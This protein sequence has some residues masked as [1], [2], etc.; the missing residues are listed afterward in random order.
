MQ[1]G[2]SNTDFLSSSSTANSA[3]GTDLSPLSTNDTSLLDAYSRAVTTAVEKVSP[4]V[5][6]VEVYQSA[7]RGRSGERR[8]G[9]SGF[10]F[11]PDGLILTNSHVV[12]DATRI[13]VTFADGTRASA[14]T[15]GDDPATDLAVIQVSAPGLTAVQ[16]GD[17]Q[18]LRPGQMAIAIGNPYGFQ[19][20]VTAGVISALG[21]SLRS[22]SGRLIEDV[23]QTDAALNPGNSGGPLVDSRGQVIGVNTATILPA[24]G[25]C[26]AIGINTAKFVAS[27]LL[28][29]GRIRRSYI[30]VSAQTVPIHRRVVRFYNLPQ[31]TGVVVLGVEERSPAQRAGL[32][33]GDV[34]VALND[35]QVAGVDDLHRLLTDAQ[36]GA[37]SMLTAIRHTERITLAISPEEAKD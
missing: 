14:R 29:D 9:G 27:R 20:T 21:R 16:F 28:R 6:N 26:F 1:L 17:S 5:V 23:I 13:S 36:V 35:K 24:Q 30:G 19:S 3:L 11:T 37:R 22:Y 33:E 7:G 12:H 8:G 2:I 25:I 34:I 32:R 4:S 31:E 15:I 18:Q 10:V